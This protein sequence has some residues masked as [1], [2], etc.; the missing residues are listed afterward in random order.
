M[1][2]T[3]LLGVRPGL[4]VA[5][6]LA[7][8]AGLWTVRIAR[9]SVAKLVA[10]VRTETQA[11]A[12]IGP[13]LIEVE[14]EV[15]SAGESVEGRMT[16]EEA[17]VTEYRRRQDEPGHDDTTPN[18]PIPQQLVPTNM[19]RGAVPFFVEDDTGRVL[20]DAANASLSL[21]S[22][23][24]GH[25]S[26]RETREVEARLEPGDEVYVI[27]EAVPVEEYSPEEDSG[28]VLRLLFGFF[29]GEHRRVPA[30]AVMDEVGEDKLVI[31]Q[32][33]QSQFLI[34]DTAEW[35]GWVRQGLMIFLWTVVSLLFIAGGGYFFL[36][37]IVG[38]PSLP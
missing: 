7:V 29:L 32:Q 14:G 6:L 36:D 10:M 34:A 5:G 33:G 25:S 17:V 22:D 4:I 18:I 13:G 24:R 37:G 19:N 11:V 38:L 27:G 1:V 35:R 26:G 12:N 28:G 30:S 21:S 8:L 31:T 9:Q 20:V 16:G 23:A 2:S 15:V 3:L